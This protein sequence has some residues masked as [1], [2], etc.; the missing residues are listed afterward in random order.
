MLAANNPNN[1]A[2]KYY[3]QDHILQVLYYS[4]YSLLYGTTLVYGIS[5]LHIYPAPYMWEPSCKEIKV[6]YNK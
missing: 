3:V 6:V 4:I 5:L 1:W 2:T